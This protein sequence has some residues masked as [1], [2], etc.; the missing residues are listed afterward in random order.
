[1]TSR[2]P[3]AA[4]FYID[5]QSAFELEITTTPAD[6]SLS[7]SYLRWWATRIRSSEPAYP[8]QEIKNPVLPIKIIIPAAANVSNTSSHLDED[9]QIIVQFVLSNGHKVHKIFPYTIIS[10]PTIPYFEE[11]LPDYGSSIGGSDGGSSPSL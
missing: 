6:P 8:M 2:R 7:I 1:M 5:E 10:N 3:S 9:R 11:E 4:P